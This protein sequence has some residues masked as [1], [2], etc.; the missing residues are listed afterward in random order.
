M[1]SQIRSL[2]AGSVRGDIRKGLCQHFCL[3]ESYPCPRHTP[4]LMLDK[5]VP[6]HTPLVPFKLLLL[7]WSSEGVSPSQSIHGP[8]RRNCLGLQKF[9]SPTASGPAGFYGQKYGD[10]SS[11]HWNPRLEGWDPPLLIYPSRF[12]SSTCECGPSHFCASAPPASLHVV[13]SSIP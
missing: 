6:L 4:V 1:E 2:L 13:S 7:C 3:G 11:W 5:S 12:L 10:F 8:F 9:L